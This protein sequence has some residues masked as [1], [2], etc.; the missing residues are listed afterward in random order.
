MEAYISTLQK[1]C[2]SNFKMYVGLFEDASEPN[3]ALAL[4]ED[5]P[6]IREYIKIDKSDH[7]RRFGYRQCIWDRVIDRKEKNKK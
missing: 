7:W 5:L 6:G 4:G 3:H 1:P 2:F